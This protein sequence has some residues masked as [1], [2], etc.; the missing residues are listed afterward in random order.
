MV[1][2]ANDI[3]TYT[4][5]VDAGDIV[6]QLAT[7]IEW[8]DHIVFLGFAYHDQNMLLLKPSEELHAT[9]TLFGTAF[10]MSDSDVTV[11]GHQ[12]DSWFKGRDARGYRKGMINVDNT[13]KCAGLFDYYAKS[14]TGDR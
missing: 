11:T 3:K 8:A 9:K 5:Q 6:K 4:E 10:G 7:L 12:L 2:L 14:L 1:K 13:L